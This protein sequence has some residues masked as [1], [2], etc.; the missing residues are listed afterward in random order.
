MTVKSVSRIIKN[1]VAYH[2]EVYI[3]VPTPQKP[4]SNT[5]PGGISAP[6]SPMRKRTV[7][8]RWRGTSTTGVF[9]RIWKDRCS[10]RCKKQAVLGS[11]L[12]AARLLQSV[13]RRHS[14]HVTVLVEL[15]DQARG[16]ETSSE[17][18]NHGSN[19]YLPPIEPSFSRH[20][21][22]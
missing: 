14:I 18:E 1:R 11:K 15:A 4:K 3:K 22:E 9:T 2:N 6:G 17:N 16:I 20:D 12:S 21:R 13:A 7:D 10:E 8:A 19:R 5:S